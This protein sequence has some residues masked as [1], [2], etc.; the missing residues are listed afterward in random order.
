M[1]KQDQTNGNFQKVH[2]LKN[3]Y[4]GEM[5]I[6]NIIICTI[7]SWNIAL[8]EK[9]KR[10]SKHNVYIITEKDQLNFSN[11]KKIDPDYIFFPHWS[12]YISEDIYKTFQCVLFH[13]TDLPFG[14]GGSP[15]QNLIERGYSET[16]IS[17]IK[18]VGDVDA[19]PIYYKEP[20]PLYGSASEI[21]YRASKIIFNKMIPTIIKENKEPVMQTGEVVTFERRT[22]EQ[23]ELY[24]NMKLEQIYDHI[25]MLDA[26]GYPN[27]Y[28]KFGAFKISF[29]KA[30]QNF[31]S[32]T[33]HAEIKEEKYDE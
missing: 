8:A 22:P 33:C 23:S 15:L 28:I 12:Y 17:A 29:S 18:V 3:L 11:V 1:L 19:G 7:K 21:Y 30:L 9:L 13:M 2:F 27:A 24:S 16:F 31:D 5:N 4:L 14:R 26:E 32:I 20:L 25:R 6:M 10:K